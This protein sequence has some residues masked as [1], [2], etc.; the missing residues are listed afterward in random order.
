MNQKVIRRFYAASDHAGAVL[1]NHIIEHLSMQGFEVVDLGAEGNVP[2]D[3]PD[4]GT[5]LAEAL[6]SDCDA[7]GVAICGSGIGISIAANRFSHIR[8][9]LVSDVVGAELSRRHNDA[10]VL[11]LG[12]RLIDKRTAL[13]CVEIFASTNFEGGRHSV[14]VEKLTN[15]RRI[16]ANSSS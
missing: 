12:E 2:V 1:K 13:N 9:A 6:L 16:N 11:A 4:Y 15:P 14:R 7:F 10:N 3:Y 8:A 5:T